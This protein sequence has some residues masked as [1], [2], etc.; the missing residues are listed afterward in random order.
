MK[1]SSSERGLLVKTQN[2]ELFVPCIGV[3]SFFA[4]H[5]RV[6]IVEGEEKDSLT[7]CKK[8]FSISHAPTGFALLHVVRWK[9]KAVEIIKCLQVLVRSGVISSEVSSSDPEKVRAAFPDK[10]L[11]FLRKIRDKHAYVSKA[12]DL[13]IKDLFDEMF[14]SELNS[15]PQLTQQSLFGKQEE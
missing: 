1:N 11:L 4:V 2:E 13:N 14:R 5:S 12:A 9:S 7:L 6:I 15:K 3:Y 10:V 8:S